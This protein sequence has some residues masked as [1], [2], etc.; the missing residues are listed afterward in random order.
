MTFAR[1]LLVEYTPNKNI[2]F[3]NLV[4]PIFM[5]SETEDDHLESISQYSD[6][7][8]YAKYE[9]KYALIKT[10]NTLVLGDDRTN[11]EFSV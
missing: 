10:T 8:I 7:N 11:I 5:N 6:Y 1:G 3:T 9:G 2:G 4:Y